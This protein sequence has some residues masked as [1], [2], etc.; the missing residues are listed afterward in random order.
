[1]F[2]WV[3][4]ALAAA[5]MLELS[6]VLRFGAAGIFAPLVLILLVGFFGVRWFAGFLAF[7]LVLLSFLAAPFWILEVGGVALIALLLLIAA[8][9]LTGNRFIDFLILLAAGTATIA[10]GG[11]WIHGGVS[12]GA[13]FVTLLLNL[14]VGAAAFALIDRY[15]PAARPFAL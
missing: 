13:V 10:I 9:F 12:L 7:F 5:F 15:A 3:S 4:T 1:M 2:A 14:G 11:A 8:P 6:G